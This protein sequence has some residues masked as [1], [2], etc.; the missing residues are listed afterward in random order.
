MDP[1][2]R[3]AE[4][5]LQLVRDGMVI[6]LGT[7]STADYF[8]QG[9]A[10]ALRDGRLRDVRGIPTSRQSEIRAVDLS[11]PL[12]T[13]TQ[14]SPDITIDGADEV[15]PQLNLIKGLGGALLREKMVAQHS[16]Q[17]III[18][19]AGKAVPKLGTKSALPVEVAQF[20]HEAHVA[21]FRTLGA[22]PTLRTTSDGA[23]Y[24]TDNGNYIYDCRFD[25]IDDPA[26]LDAA[27]HA[28]A[29]VVETGLFLRLAAVALIAH[30][31]R[32][33]QRRRA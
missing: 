4:A 8:L 13:L 5:S 24:V 19:D 23:A 17:L 15:D 9:L 30:Q 1:K 12:T 3:A 33:E 11:I 25:G 21:F 27:L 10:A 6:G 16:R 29:G 7:G 26:A 32:V 31:H 20:A 28:R 22:T 14:D 18:A 2:Q